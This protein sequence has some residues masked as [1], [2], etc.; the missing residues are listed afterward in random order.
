MKTHSRSKKKQIPPFWSQIPNFFLYA[1]SPSPLLL[2][3]ILAAICA[4]LHFFVVYLLVFAVMSKY[5]FEVLIHTSEGEMT[6]PGYGREVLEENYGLVFKQIG[7]Y[8]FFIA[9]FITF[10]AQGLM[11]LAQATLIF[12]LFLLPAMIMVL[13]STNSLFAAINPLMLIS[14]V[15]RVGWS[16]LG[17]YGLLMMVYVAEVN[18]Q[19]LLPSNMDPESLLPIFIAINLFFSVLAHHM[20]GYLLY[21]HHERLGIHQRVSDEEELDPTEMKLDLF[22]T[23]MDDNKLDAA[24]AELISLAKENPG[25]TKLQQKLSTFLLAH[26]SEEERLSFARY[27][28]PILLDS[29]RASVAAKL[30]LELAMPDQPGFQLKQANHYQLLAKALYH[31]G[32]LRPGLALV[33]NLHK[34]FPQTAAVADAYLDAAHILSD[35]FSQDKTALQMLTFITNGFPTHPR[36][37]EAVQLATTIRQLSST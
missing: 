10:A 32:Q 23:Y 17:L 12:F 34:R 36:H 8:L 18:T 5:A 11:L 2:C 3:I 16:Y 33:K 31:Q 4:V 22:Y 24:K 29:E 35:K 7:I 25:D 9:L 1:L 13:A 15:A 37:A 14:M 30:Y 19:S 26:G 21:Q 6:P 28:L 27:T 20:M